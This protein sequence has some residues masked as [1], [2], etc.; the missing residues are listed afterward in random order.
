MINADSAYWNLRFQLPKIQ[1]IWTPQKSEWKSSHFNSFNIGKTAIVHQSYRGSLTSNKEKEWKAY[2]SF[3]VVKWVNLP[4]ESDQWIYPQWE[5]IVEG[6]IFSLRRMWNKSSYHAVS[7]KEYSLTQ[8]E[9]L[10]KFLFAYNAIQKQAIPN[11]S[12]HLANKTSDKIL[13]TLLKHGE[14]VC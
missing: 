13:W 2:I 7:R 6:N 9:G 12:M 11:I 4:H 5:I 10:F 8:N 3:L 1:S 14:S